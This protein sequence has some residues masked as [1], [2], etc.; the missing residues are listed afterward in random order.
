[1]IYQ[2]VLSKY[3]SIVDEVILALVSDNMNA[4]FTIMP[5]LEE[6]SN[7]VFSLDID[8][9]RMPD[10]FWAVFYQ[11]YLDI[12]KEDVCNVVLQLFSHGMILPN[13]NSNNIVL[14]RKSNNVDS[15]DMIRLFALTNFK[16]KIISK[17]LADRLASIVPRIT[18]NEHRGLIQG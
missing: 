4:L 6:I 9:D 12:I 1:M 11:T 10:D 16:F 3:L 14:L 15:I 5:S 8:N 17:V 13:F 18:S 2:W 7:V